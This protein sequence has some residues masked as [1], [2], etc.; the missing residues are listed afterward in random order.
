MTQQRRQVFARPQL[1]KGADLLQIALADFE[2]LGR[3]ARSFQPALN[4]SFA[5]QTV[6]FQSNVLIGGKKCCEY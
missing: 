5:F 2:D 4:N 1:Y 6:P 3:L